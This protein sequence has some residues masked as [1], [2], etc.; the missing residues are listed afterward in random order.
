MLALLL[1]RDAVHIYNKTKTLPVANRSHVQ[2]TIVSEAAFLTDRVGGRTVN[3]IGRVSALLF[4]CLFPLHLLHRMTFDI[5]CTYRTFACT[6]VM[7]MARIGLKFKVTV[8]QRSSWLIGGRCTIDCCSGVVGCCLH[9]PVSRAVC[10]LSW[11]VA[12]NDWEWATG[13]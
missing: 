2:Y 12:S 9:G 7:T 13:R 10:Q 5:R 3:P 1:Y 8:G 6:L 4:V 11:E